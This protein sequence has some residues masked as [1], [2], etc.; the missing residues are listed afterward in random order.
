MSLINQMLRDLQ[1]R[2]A[3]EVEGELPERVRP[4]PG[5]SR[6]VRRRGA[7]TWIIAGVLLSLAGLGAAGWFVAQ[8]PGALDMLMRMPSALVSSSPPS[9]QPAA[10]SVPAP[11]PVAAATGTT[12]AAPLAD[13]LSS[14]LPALTRTLPPVMTDEPAASVA[15]QASLASIKVDKRSAP[16]TSP[17]RL[18]LD[19]MLTFNPAKTASAEVS[20][21]AG[22]GVPAA[23]APALAVAI[24]AA[25]PTQAPV[26]ASPQLAQREERRRITTASSAGE[27]T[28][29]VEKTLYNAPGDEQYRNAL[30]SIKQGRNSEAITRLRAALKEHARHVKAR[31]ALLALLVEQK[32]WDDALTLLDEGL[33]LVPDQISWAM[34]AARIQVERGRMADAWTLLQKHQDA[35][36]KNAEYH[37]FAGVLLLHLKQPHQAAEHYQA[38]V[39]LKP[40]EGRWW[41]AL[42]VAL[43]ANR[44]PA[45]AAEAWQQALETGGLTQ[46]MT[47]AIEKRLRRP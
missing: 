23:V 31:H 9:P 36:E 42:G 8:Q 14:L 44:Q 26:L 19:E 32:H 30:Q 39:R 21:A 41:Y 35:G 33:A 1:S 15:S 5:S 20:S 16:T 7:R 10:A 46:T 29:R 45:E 11:G 22:Q 40:R 24:V 28:Q 47:D 37:S 17:G 25:A 12:E 34:A 4:S 38:A 43:E 27:L 18:R 6:A 3:D 13:D 2:H